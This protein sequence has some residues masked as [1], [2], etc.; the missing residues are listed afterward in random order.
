MVITNSQ[1][2]EIHA[3]KVLL[4]VYRKIVHRD[5]KG[6]NIFLNKD[7]VCKIGDFGISKI[8]NKTME[9]HKSFV[10]TPSYLSP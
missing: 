1:R 5:I 6:A 3:L 7:N 10:G 2:I 8:M 4:K 9:T